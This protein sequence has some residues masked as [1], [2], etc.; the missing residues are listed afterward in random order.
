[1][2]RRIFLGALGTAPLWLG[3]CAHKEETPLAHLYG[4]DWVHGAYELYA[5]KYA[6]I[7]TSSE[8]ATKSAYAMLAQKGVTALDALQTREVPFFI[9]VDASEQGFS[10]QRDVPERLTFT[11]DMSQADREAAQARWE[12]ARESIQ[13]DYEQ[14]RR[15]DWALTTL[16]AQTQHVRSAIDNGKIEQY[17]LVRQLSALA[18]GDKPPFDLPYQVS[19][20][21]Y[22]DVLLLLLERLDD[23][24][25]RL[26]RVESDIVTVGLTARATDAGSGSLAAN[27][28]KVLL[29]VVTDADATSPRAA[30]YPLEGDARAQYVAQGKALYES[31]KTSPDYVTWEKHESTKAFDQLGQMLTLVDSMTGLHVSAIYKQVLDV[32]RG[33][34][35]YLSYL[36]S[37]VRMLPG[38]SEVAKVADQAIELTE[39]TRKVVGQV[40][41]GIATAQSL[42]G[43][44]Q[45]VVQLTKDGGLLN[46]GSDFARSKLS[47]QIAF[48]KDQSELQQ[49]QGLIADSALARSALPTL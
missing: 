10:V 42:A 38:G 22:R 30:S 32:W 9:R 47:R 40:Q 18:E 27:L 28:Q 7:Q 26:A 8:Q 1:M 2:R 46:A 45:G 19:V 21:D 4:T 20:A 35:D 39:K 11:S 5:G 33:D 3:A 24:A 49:V 16:L 36:K 23:D 31:I 48:I 17:R 25:K 6:S 12:K 15:L 44:A 13:T 34:A 29:A 37:V 41:K 43:Q 14:I